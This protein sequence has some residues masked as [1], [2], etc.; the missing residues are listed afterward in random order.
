MP[1]LAPSVG[2]QCLHLIAGRLF[3]SCLAQDT[4][5]GTDLTSQFSLK[6]MLQVKKE[7]R[8]ELQCKDDELEDARAASGKKVKTLMIHII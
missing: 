4:H 2:R 8:R 5:L 7:S 1:T 3:V 6:L